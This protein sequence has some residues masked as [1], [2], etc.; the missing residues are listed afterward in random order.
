MKEFDYDLDY[1]QLDFTDPATRRLSGTISSA[2][3]VST[4]CHKA[5]ST[6]VDINASV[7]CALFSSMLNSMP[8]GGE[9][10]TSLP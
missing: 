4:K 2:R 8:V 6:S 1:K 3:P 9:E 7:R 10:I 5:A